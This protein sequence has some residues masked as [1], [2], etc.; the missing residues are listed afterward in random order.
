MNFKYKLNQYLSHRVIL[1]PLDWNQTL[2]DAHLIYF[3]ATVSFYIVVKYL[4]Y[5]IL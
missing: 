4:K 1:N 5:T 2:H 3:H